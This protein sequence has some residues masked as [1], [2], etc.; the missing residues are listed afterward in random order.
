MYGGGLNIGIA[1]SCPLSS[2]QATLRTGN[3]VTVPSRGNLM[4]LHFLAL[5]GLTIGFI[6]PTMA[7]ENT[8]TCSGPQD[9]CRQIT[10]RA[11]AFDDAFNKKDAAALAANYTPD[12]ISIL[13]MPVLY[14]REA[15]A[16]AFS[17]FFKR[18]QPTL[19]RP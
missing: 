18:G 6:L 11:K 3:N 1:V 7:Q 19:S 2:Q 10:S 14:G 15:I 13:E 12:G 8:G 16:H 9:D 4:K 5:A 17:E